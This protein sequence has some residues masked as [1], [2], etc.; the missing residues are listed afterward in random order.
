M[1]QRRR[2]GLELKR[3]V[4]E[5]GPVRCVAQCIFGLL[6][7]GAVP[8]HKMHRAAHDHPPRHA[9]ELIARFDR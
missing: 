8:I 1:V 7:A 3:H 2:N 5:P 4:L 6:I 9:T